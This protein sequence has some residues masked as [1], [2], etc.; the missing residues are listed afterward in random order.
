[1]FMPL[2]FNDAD[3][4]NTEGERETE[5]EREKGRRRKEQQEGGWQIFQN[6]S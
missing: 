1:M 4:V 2:L 6:M 3:L 5:T